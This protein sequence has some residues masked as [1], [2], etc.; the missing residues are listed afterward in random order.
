MGSFLRGV[1]L[2]NPFN[3]YGN[4]PVQDARLQECKVFLNQS[5]SEIKFTFSCECITTESSFGDKEQAFKNTYLASKPDV[6]GI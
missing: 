6:Q 5:F 1:A 2:T 4:A 3:V